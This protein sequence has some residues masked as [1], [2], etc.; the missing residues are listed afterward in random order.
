MLGRELMRGER[1]LSNGHQGLGP[2]GFQEIGESGRRPWS[3]P[4]ETSSHFSAEGKLPFLH[5]VL[6]AN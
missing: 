3:H 2:L 6:D 1:F 4:E 5:P